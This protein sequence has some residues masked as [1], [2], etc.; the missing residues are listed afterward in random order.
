MI[1]ISITKVVPGWCSFP[2]FT[3]GSVAYGGSHQ[4]LTETTLASMPILMGARV[5]LASIARFTSQDPVPG[6]NANAYAYSLDPINFAD[7]SGMS[8]CA[9]LCVTLGPGGLQAAIG[10]AQIQPTV[11]ASRVVYSVAKTST[12]RVTASAARA[13]A[14]AQHTATVQEEH[15]IVE[16]NTFSFTGL[17]P[18]SPLATAKTSAGGGGAS[19]GSGLQSAFSAAFRVGK[20]AAGGCVGGVAVVAGTVYAVPGGLTAAAGAPEAFAFALASTCVSGALGSSLTYA[21]TGIDAP[22]SA[23]DDLR[24][25][26]EF[27]LGR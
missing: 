1:R 4:K 12:V 3:Q 5:Y 9:I 15:Q 17:T 25:G 21:A 11:S 20:I 8:S 22:G 16:H 26:L 14:P 10:A 13:Q 2:N 23:I 6:G 24:E 7:L 27:S 19:S 18:E